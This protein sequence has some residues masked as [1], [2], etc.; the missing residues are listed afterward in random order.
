MLTREMDLQES[1]SENDDGSID[2]KK[3]LQI[4]IK[5]MQEEINNLIKINKIIPD[6]TKGHINT[7]TNDIQLITKIDSTIAN[8]LL[9]LDLVCSDNDDDRDENDDDGNEDE[10][11]DDDENKD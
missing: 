3:T 6:G 9:S 8:N 2:V 1:V 4:Q 7:D 5:E 11:D 10:N